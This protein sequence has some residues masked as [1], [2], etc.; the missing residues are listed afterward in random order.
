MA[1]PVLKAP[2]PSTWLKRAYRPLSLCS[3]GASL[4]SWS[5]SSSIEVL[6]MSRMRPTFAAVTTKP[7]RG[8][9]AVAASPSSARGA[10]TRTCH[11]RSEVTMAV[12]AR[13]WAHNPRQKSDMLP[14]IVAASDTLSSCD[15][16]VFTCCVYHI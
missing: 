7:A 9:V 15:M 6:S 14:S 4:S 3:T 12:A 10:L 5:S 8:H 16:I 2:R 13:A 11:R 1:A